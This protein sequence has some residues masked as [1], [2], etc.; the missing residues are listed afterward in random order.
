MARTLRHV[1]VR[2]RRRRRDGSLPAGASRLLLAVIGV[3]FGLTVQ[4]VTAVGAVSAEQWTAFAAATVAA[5]V[6]QLYV[7]RAPRNQ[8]FHSAVV[9]VVAAATLLPPALLLLMCVAQHLP[10]WVKHRYPW[11]IQ[12]F[13]ICNYALNGVA[14]A[15][16]V[17]QLGGADPASPRFIAF[18]VV[19]AVVF[20]LGQRVLLATMLWLARGL[21]LRDSRL[22]A[23]Q[24]L[25]VD[26]V[27]A[28]LG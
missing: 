10:D 17:S 1:P 13:N 14:A 11:Y 9:F 8:V 2:L 12:S 15:A 23:P 20:V 24:S 25:S 26:G 27:L 18:A 19:A 6:G 7:I 4:L 22:F 16:I 3:T 28:A 5:S 21:S